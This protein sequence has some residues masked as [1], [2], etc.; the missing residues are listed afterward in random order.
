INDTAVIADDLA[1]DAQAELPAAPRRVLFGAGPDAT[2]RWTPGVVRGP[3]GVCV[4]CA[5]TPF[6]N[7][8]LGLTA[9]AACAAVAA[10]G[11]APAA[12]GAAMRDFKTLPHRMQTVGELHGVRFVDNSKATTLAAL[13]AAVRMAGGPVRLIAGGQL[14]EKDLTGVKKVLSNCVRG[15]Y[16]IGNSSC[17]LAEAWG[18]AAPCVVC[19]DL[20]CA[21]E[22][23]WKEAKAG[24]VILLAPGGASFDQ[25]RG[26]DDRGNQFSEMVQLIVRGE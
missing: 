13:A 8:I 9:A 21:V 2:W 12:V 19:G 4:A 17:A 20:R 3:G 1:S 18:D 7:E 24:E 6:D 22:R 16:T 14:K 11:V 23:A 10:C 25:F 15:I 26:F 5:G